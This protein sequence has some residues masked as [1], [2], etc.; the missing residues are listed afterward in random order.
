[1]ITIP[2]IVTLI[3][4]VVI[5]QFILGLFSPVVLIIGH[6]WSNEPSAMILQV[7][8]MVSL[9]A[10]ILLVGLVSEYTPGERLSRWFDETIEA[11]PGLGTVYQSLREASNM[12]LDEDV[13]QF[14]DVKLVEFPHQ[15]AYML[16]F[17]TADTP[18]TIE[19]SVSEDDMQTVMIP[20]GPNPTT[21]GYI[22][23]I[24]SEHM[25]DV[26]ITVDE[27]I[28]MTATLGVTT[29]EIEEDS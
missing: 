18:E 15:D 7:A 12:L 25:Y 16:A 27:A 22:L 8:T 17:L 11:I 20:L 21:N 28:G 5:V 14:Q 24:P 1:M 29:D 26:D 10:F 3:I 19:K 4:L 6:L 23:H 9:I 2:L 13:D